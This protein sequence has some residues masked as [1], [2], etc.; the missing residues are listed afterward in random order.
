MPVSFDQQSYWH[1]RF[2]SETAFEWL[3]PSAAFLAILQPI[4]ATLPPT[5]AILHLGP[6]TSDLHVHL[7]A[8]GLPRVTN[9]DYEPLAAD[10]GRELEARAFGDVRMAYAVA[11]ATRLD[12]ARDG[13]DL[14]LDKSTADAVACAGDDA[15]RR[16]AAGVRQ[17]LGPGGAWVSLSYSEARF[18]VEGL[19]FEVEVLD[20][21][22]VPKQR[23]Q[24]PDIYHWCYLLR[25]R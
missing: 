24:D 17:C 10:R 4:L 5:A 15:L 3:V 1:D 19:P 6:G 7:R 8:A 25:P 14:V 18:K 9:L 20:R 16:M 12:T 2:T 22:P 13:F 21:I 11:D 23:P